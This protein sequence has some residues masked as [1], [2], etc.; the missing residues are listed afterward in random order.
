MHTNKLTHNQKKLR[1]RILEI[2]YEAQLSHLG[3]CLTSVDAID[4]VFKHKRKQDKFVLSNGHAG[5]AYYTVLEKYHLLDKNVTQKLYIHPDRNLDNNIHV[6]TGSLG[7]GLPIAVGM[8]LANKNQHI[9]CMLS[10]GECGEGSVWE[11]FRIIQEQQLANITCLI[12]ANGWAAYKKIEI[13]RLKKQVLGFI[14]LVTQISGNNLP[15]LSTLIKQSVNQKQPQVIILK[16]KVEHF[17]FLKDQA[18][19]YHVMSKADFEQAIKEL[20]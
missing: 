12:N 16:T 10:D 13:S 20:S 17:S 6:S 2:S 11:S 5:I 8:A 1:Q 19:H 14:D 7:Q 3:S 18:A 4:L 9:F 15:R